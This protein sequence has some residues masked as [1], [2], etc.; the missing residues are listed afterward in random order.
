MLKI[1]PLLFFTIGL[2]AQNFLNGSFENS[3]AAMSCQ[4]NLTNATFNGLMSDVNA[5]GPGQELDILI[6][7]CF[8]PAIPD[9]V[10]AVGVADNPSDEMALALSAPLV[11]GNSYT[12]TFDSYAEISFRA[13]GNLEI[14]ASTSNSAFGSLIYTATTVANTWTNHSISFTAPNNATH[15]TVRNVVGA[16]HWNHVDNFELVTL[17]PIHIQDF[18]AKAQN[19][20]VKLSW[21]TAQEFNNNYFILQRSIDGIEWSDLER[22]EGQGT[23]EELSFYQYNDLH[24]QT[25]TNYY[26][27]IQFDFDGNRTYSNVKAVDFDQHYPNQ[28]QLYPNP[29]TGIVNIQLGQNLP[30]KSIR[31]FNSLG[32]LVEHYSNSE[33][34]LNLNHL[35]KGIYHLEIE[36]TDNIYIQKQ[37][38]L[39]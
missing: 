24:P 17:L 21:V 32:Q 33:T 15:I 36:T 31:I 30:V 9:G 18:N 35:E 8:Q 34:V 3:T 23:S 13:Q 12:I 39:Y 22:I 5:Y 27:L 38:V 10:R 16:I 26:R 4:Y 11:A 1:L 20:T 2:S 37:L 29:S 25:G 19:E 28:L 14:G 7:G 6:N